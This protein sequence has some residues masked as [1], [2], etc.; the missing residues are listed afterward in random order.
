MNLQEIKEF[1]KNRPG[2]IKE[3]GKRLRDCLKNKGFDTTIKNYV[4]T[5]SGIS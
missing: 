3:G 1:L 4:G 2:Y 5:S